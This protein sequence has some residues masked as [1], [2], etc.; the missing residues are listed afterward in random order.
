M[1]QPRLKLPRTSAKPR[2]PGPKRH[3]PT[4]SYPGAA[5]AESRPAKTRQGDG[6][7]QGSPDHEETDVVEDYHHQ[8]RPPAMLRE[9]DPW[10]VCEC[11]EESTLGKGGHRRTPGRP[12]RHP[13][14][15]SLVGRSGLLVS[16]RRRRRRSAP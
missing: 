8:T 9:T 10:T 16:V 4:S 12:R 15:L 11:G 6:T 5:P 3:P 2:Q 13:P 14:G 1:V 7:R